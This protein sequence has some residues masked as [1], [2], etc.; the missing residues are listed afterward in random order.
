MDGSRTIHQIAFT[1]CFT[2]SWHALHECANFI[3]LSWASLTSIETITRAYLMRCVA[4]S[5]IQWVF[6]LFTYFLEQS[7]LHLW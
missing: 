2:P 1:R 7:T 4:L 3:R 5:A 6:T